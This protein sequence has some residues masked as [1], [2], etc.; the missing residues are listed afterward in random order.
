[1]NIIKRFYHYYLKK[2]KPLNYAKKIGVKMGT[3]IH[4][5]G[6]ILWGSEP[7]LI[8]LGNN[9]YITNGCRFI[10]HDGG[11]LILR[12]YIPDLELTF[13]I[14]IKNDVY[15]GIN[16]IILPGVTIG[17]NCIIGAGS[18]VTKDIPDNSVYAGVP[19]KYI[20]STDDYL[21]KIKLKSLGFG[22]LNSID[23]EKKL[24]EFYGIT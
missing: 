16:S 21:E 9:V 12:K 8:S 1:M 24:K 17:N 20:K 19:A 2:T 10:T 4:L 6:D 18:V 3:N 7:W 5:Y 13:P 22:N 11:T 14:T 23:K 15:I